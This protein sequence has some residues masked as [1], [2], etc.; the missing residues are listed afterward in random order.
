MTPTH[1]DQYLNYNSHH[2]LHQKLGVIRTLYDRKDRVITEEED[3]KEEEKKVQDALQLCGYPTWSFDKVKQR[4][5][6]PKVKKKTDIKKDDDTRSRGFVVLPYVKGVSERIARTMKTYQISTAMKPHCTIRNQLVHPKDK[7]EPH[8]I[9][10]A[11]Y[12]IPCKNCDK[13]YI[14]ETGRKFG[15]R[16]S[17]H[18]KEA[19]KAN[20]TTTT[21]A[22]RKASLT[23]VNKSAITDHVV[24]SN[25]VIGWDEAKVIGTEQDKYK[26]WIREAIEI[27]RRGD[28]TMNRDEGQYYLTHVFDDLLSSDKKSPD[29]KSTGN[30]KTAKSVK[31]RQD[32][33]YHK[34]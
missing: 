29:D 32:H 9:S 19:E 6:T 3:K 1:T 4:M 24:D 22:A 20:N 12:N 23:T 16:L 30:F 21:R 2:P 15:T 7:R 26:R 14:G 5:A 27:R 17:E 33:H 34:C 31:S 8:S 25:H 10:D 28:S 13:S 11:I 18:K